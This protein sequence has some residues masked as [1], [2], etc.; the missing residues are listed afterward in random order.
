MQ[1][2][3]LHAVD[4]IGIHFVHEVHYVHAFDDYPE[5]WLPNLG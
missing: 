4:S 2:C 3:I 5:T 1:F